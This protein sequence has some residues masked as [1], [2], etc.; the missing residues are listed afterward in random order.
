MAAGILFLDTVHP[1]LRQG[2]EKSG[3]HCDENLKCSYDELSRIIGNYT[4]IVL[5]SRL[6]IDRDLILAA[7]K[8]KFIARSGSGMENI[9]VKSAAERNVACVN[10]PEGNRD[11]VAEH[12]LGMLLS[13]MNNLKKAD[14]EVR[15]GLWKREENRGWEISGKT[16]GIIG[17]GN[18]GSAFAARL[19]GFNCRI[20]VYDKFISG[21]G[22]E[23]VQ[24]SSEAGIFK[25]AD[26]VSL[27][28]PLNA[29]NR[30]YAGENF[31]SS[32][33]K[34]IWFINTSRGEVL[35]TAALAKAMQDG[36]ISGACLDVIEY[37]SASF[38]GL[39]TKKFPPDFTY[40]AS[41]KNVLFSPHIAGW[42][43]ESYEKLSLVLLE[44][45]TSLGI[46]P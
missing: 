4:G 19:K 12:A 37:E 30:Y 33:R 10:S 36:K 44:K 18:T 39:E 15:T 21:F 43:H 11:A 41:H 46:Q 28:I 38:E 1:V 42:T 23:G 6:V 22:K 8:L 3:F 2:L 17:Y 29:E 40:L 20:L 9:D 13:V 16:V 31:F 5:R 26:I 34:K 14:E 25:D 7:G 35:S 45:I 24:E 27:H 32:F